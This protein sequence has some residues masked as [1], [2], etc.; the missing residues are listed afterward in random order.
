MSPIEAPKTG[1][2][3]RLLA[4]SSAK[5][6]INAPTADIDITD[7]VFH[8]GDQEYIDCTPVSHAHLSAGF[9]TSPDGKPMSLNTEYIGGSLICEH[10]NQVIGEKLHCRLESISDNLIGGVFT[11]THVIW[12]LIAKHVDGDHHEFTNNV[13]V[14]TTEKFEQYIEALRIP[15]E[16]ARHNYQTSVEAHNQEETPYFAAAIER[17]ALRKKK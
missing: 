16:T 11:T 8:C 12:E 3:P 17:K 15:Y 1:F 4:E 5:F 9:T 10:Y 2:K 14:H 7:W 6:H 13:W